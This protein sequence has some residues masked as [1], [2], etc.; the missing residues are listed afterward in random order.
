MIVGEDS[1]LVGGEKRV[2]TPFADAGGKQ[3]QPSRWVHCFPLTSPIHSSI[4]FRVLCLFVAQASVKNTDLFLEWHITSWALYR[5]VKGHAIIR[6]LGGLEFFPS[7]I[8][9]WRGVAKRPGADGENNY[10]YKYTKSTY[11]KSQI[12]KYKYGIEEGR[13]RGVDVPCGKK[14]RSRWREQLMS[15]VS[16]FPIGSVLVIEVVQCR[17]YKYQY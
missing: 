15:V 4:I 6:W 13:W 7:A 5:Q 12:R 1:A 8:R 2:Q 16:S 10:K 3:Q 14:G 9:R 11:T 17:Y